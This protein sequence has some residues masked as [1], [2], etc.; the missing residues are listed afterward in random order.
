MQKAIEVRNM[1]KV[2]RIRERGTASAEGR[3]QLQGSAQERRLPQLRKLFRLRKSRSRSLVAVDGISLSVNRGEILGVLGP[4]GAG[5][6][7]LIKMLCGL[8]APD[9]GEGT[10]LGWDIWRDASKIRSRV[11]LVAP[12]ADIGTDNNLTVRE[13]LEF[14]ASVYG[15]P[16]RLKRQRIDTLLELVELKDK[17]SFWP[18]G[19]SA[20]M[21][22]RLALA[23]SLL[24][25]NA[26]VFLDEP[27][28]KLDPDGARKVRG[29]IRRINQE[30]GVT[31]VLT[32]HLMY[33]AEELC[34]RI[35]VMD[36][37]RIVAEGSPSE[38]KQL[39][40]RESV[41]EL[42]ASGLAKGVGEHVQGLPG[43]READVDIWDGSI[44]EGRILIKTGTLEETTEHLISW[45]SRRGVQVNG[46]RSGEPNLEDVFFTLTGRGLSG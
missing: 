17:E 27:T 9:G 40:G 14:W 36:Q 39:V 20:G 28:V 13:N 34:S 38:L 41:I 6:T 31:V 22:Q 16:Q 30:N 10:V 5:K 18:M 35:I 37:G 3:E 23:R 21:R 32:T 8:L 33:E 44:G 42:F 45:M 4:N 43:V 46:I 11:S 7:T 26:L 29:F 19:I 24:A 12:T 25:E 1:R 2:F 15:I